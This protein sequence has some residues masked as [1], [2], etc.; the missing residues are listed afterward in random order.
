MK[1]IWFTG[2]FNLNTTIRIV[3]S[4]LQLFE[5]RGFFHL[6]YSAI[7]NLWGVKNLLNTA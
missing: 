6:K 7:L 1:Y 4:Y 5:T 3:Y 2:K